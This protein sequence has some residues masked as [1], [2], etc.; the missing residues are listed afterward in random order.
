[1]FGVGVNQDV[2]WMGTPMLWGAYKAA[3]QDLTVT[4]HARYKVAAA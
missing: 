4:V 2:E 3:L 1:M